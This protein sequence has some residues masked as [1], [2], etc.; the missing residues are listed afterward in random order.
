M[1]SVMVLMAF[2]GEPDNLIPYI[3]RS[4]CFFHKIQCPFMFTVRVSARGGGGGGMGDNDS[5]GDIPPQL[6]RVFKKKFLVLKI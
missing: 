5:R 6:L 1:T 4:I 2:Q 3:C